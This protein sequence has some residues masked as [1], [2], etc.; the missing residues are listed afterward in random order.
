MTETPVDL[1]LLWHHH[2]PD[3]RRA[4]DHRALLPWVRLHATK[5]YL[6]MALHVERHPGVRV[7]FN[8]VP[9]LIDQLEGAARGEPDALFDLLARPIAALTDE[10]RARVA[11][12]CALGP[13]HA[14]ERWTRYRALATRVSRAPA[15]RLNEAELLELEV[16]FLVAWIDPLFHEEPEVAR[17]LEGLRAHAETHVTSRNVTPQHRDDLLALHA[18]LLA[19]VL[20]AYRRLAEQGRVELSA[21]P[22]YHPILPLLVDPRSA[23]RA[24][25][26]LA[27]PTESWSAPEDARRQLARA[28]ERHARTFG[29]TPAGVWPS[30][31]SVSPEVVELAAGLGIRWLA[32]DEGVLWASLPT[33]SRARAALYRPWRIE[34]PAGE[35]AMFFRD[36]ELSDRVGFVYQ[37]WDP[38]QAVADFLERLRKIG[39]EHRTDDAPPPVVSVILD[40][41]NCWEHFADDGRR[42]LDGLYAALAAAP[43]IRTRTPSDVLASDTPSPTLGSLH[44]GSWIDAD[45]HIWIGHPEKN[46]AWDLLARTRRS[47]VEAK[48]TVEGRPEAW[49]S[50]DRAEGSDWFWWFGDDHYTLD[51]ALFDELFRSHLVAVHEAAGLATPASLRVP[52]A[53]PPAKGAEH[54][55]PSSFVRPDVDGERTEFYEWHGAGRYRFGRGGG[56]SMH[57]GAGRVRELHYGFDLA[58]FYLRLDF[59]GSD[60]PGALFDLRLEIVTPEPATVTVAGLARGARSVTIVEPGGTPSGLADARCRIGAV[61]ELQVPFAALGLSSGSWVELAVQIVEADR[62]IETYPPDQTLRFTVPDGD[63]EA[64]NW[65]A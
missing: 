9:S 37:R 52:V 2:Q 23:R 34:T 54:V 14:L 60:P 24:R 21:S 22:Y 27:L 44:S 33:E 15:S 57:R 31:G 17:A 40:G 29:H 19:E 30:E 6:D 58:H 16:W 3:Y 56:G 32:T 61:L 49:E 18:R 8:F 43:D 39:R 51:K 11:R 20:P 28:L 48:L 50:L 47:L 65:S 63:F 4:G 1:V 35:V 12:Q 55:P 46:R 36:H 38:D 26:Q 5:D 42:F 64:A 59:A 41:E 53:A 62:A 25:P 13:P 10:E 7:T 45:F